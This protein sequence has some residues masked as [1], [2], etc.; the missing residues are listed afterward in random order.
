MKYHILLKVSRKEQAQTLETV[1]HANCLHFNFKSIAKFSFVDIKKIYCI[2][3]I[4]FPFFMII[5]KNATL[6][7]SLVSSRDQIKS[8]KKMSQRWRSIGNTA[9][10]L[11]GPKFE[12]QIYR[13]RDERVTAR[14]TGRSSSRNRFVQPFK[15][16]RK[17]SLAIEL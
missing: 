5:E 17:N 9:I 8:F 15:C 11:T 13:F 4:Y 6:F 16:I 3:I 14:P 12:P 7:L 10:Y 1:K 2:S